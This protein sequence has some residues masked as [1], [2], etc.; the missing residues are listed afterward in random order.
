MPWL[1]ETVRWC[2]RRS[3]KP[4]PTARSEGVSRSELKRRLARVEGVYVPGLSTTVTRRVLP[5]LAGSPYPEACLV[6]LT[7]GVHDRAWVE[8]MRGCTRGCRFCQAGMWYRPVRER[9]PLEIMRM[10]GTQLDSSGHQELALASLSTTDY[11]RLA[12]LLAETVRSHPEVRVSLPSLRVDTAAV[13][14]AQLASPTGPS[15]T[16]APEAGS[17]RMWDVINKNVTEA[18]VL[19]AAEEAFGSGRTTL[20][21]Y[22]M[23]GLP[24]ETD[25]DVVSI[26]ELCLRVR[27]L[28]R[29]V[30]GARAGRLQ[31][32]VSVNNFVPKPFTPFQWC[33]MADRE[34]LVRRQDL[35][36]SRLRKRGLKLTLHEVDKSYLEA[37][38]ARGGEEMG[39]VIEDAWRRGARFDSWTEQFRSDA[40]TLALAL[41]GTSAERLATTAI[42]RDS[43]LPWDVI[44]GV[45]DPRF[46]VGGMA[47]SDRR[48]GHGRLPVGK[49]HRLRGMSIPTCKRSGRVARQPGAGAGRAEGGRCSGFPSSRSD[50]G[51]PLSA[52]FLGHG[53]GPLRRSSGP[54]GDVPTGGAARRR[55]A[56]PL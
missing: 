28:G 13:K 27:D 3:F 53:E 36:R 38:L 17:R 32:N 9:S 5:R 43:P 26:A 8:I 14:L 46:P 10:A 45:V 39:R 42:P 34:T 24:L 55:T 31:L 19:A 6:P 44:M 35:L 48:C 33:G 52:C 29:R 56:G 22:F 20:K 51:E 11:T 12:E 49:L 25:D 18:D 30:L 47:A 40:W 1:W 54:G 21:L 41:A 23:I 4:C 2:S 50:P 7:A 15:L 37:A 16:L